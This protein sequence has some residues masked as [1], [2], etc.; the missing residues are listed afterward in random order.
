L[1][2]FLEEINVKF[3]KLKK[4][5]DAVAHSMEFPEN[6]D[7]HGLTKARKKDSF[8]ISGGG[9]I[10]ISDGIS[11]R[12]YFASY[13]REPLE[14]PIDKSAFDVFHTFYKHYCSAIG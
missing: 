13:Q 8:V 12:G 9:R 5:R 4:L 14:M 10:L 1:Q 6:P 3:P 11:D 2:K 7:R